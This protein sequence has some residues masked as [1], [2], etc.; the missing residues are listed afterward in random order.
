MNI[1]P[2]LMDSAKKVFQSVRVA[3]I[4]PTGVLATGALG[5]RYASTY[6]VSCHRIHNGICYGVRIR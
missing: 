2:R 1:P 3:N 5:P 4:H 6:Y